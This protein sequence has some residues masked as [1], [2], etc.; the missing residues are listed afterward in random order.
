MLAFRLD[1]AS[2]STSKYDISGEQQRPLVAYGKLYKYGKLIKFVT[3]SLDFYSRQHGYAKE[4]SP[5][6][7]LSQED[8]PDDEKKRS[9]SDGDPGAVERPRVDSSQ[10]GGSS[11]GF[12]NF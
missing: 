4:L 6:H 10:V 3:L 2:F 1:L 8:G 7:K 5:A 11:K 9:L 12:R